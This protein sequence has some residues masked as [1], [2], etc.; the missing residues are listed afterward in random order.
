MNEPFSKND[1]LKLIC[2]VRPQRKVGKVLFLGSQFLPACM[3]LRPSVL[4]KSRNDERISIKFD[5]G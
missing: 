1:F 4:N 5:I 2:L 3:S